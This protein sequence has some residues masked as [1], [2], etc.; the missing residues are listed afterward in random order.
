MAQYGG[1]PGTGSRMRLYMDVNSSPA[2]NLA[3]PGGVIWLASCEIVDLTMDDTR[4]VAEMRRRC[5]DFAKGLPAKRNVITAE[6]RLVFGLDASSRLLFINDYEQSR[7][8]WYQIVSTPSNTDPD[9]VAFV[10]PA[11]VSAFPWDQPLEDTS[12]HD[13][14]LT[15]GYMEDDVEGEVDPHWV[16]PALVTG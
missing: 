9:S 3:G 14:V 16:A 6:F 15:C 7:V 5:N 11:F 12:G 13:I 8:R 2:T 4:N 10:F 1:G